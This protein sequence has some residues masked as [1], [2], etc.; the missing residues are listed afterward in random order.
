MKSLMAAIAAILLLAALAI[1]AEARSHK[2]HHHHLAALSQS[3]API[4]DSSDPRPGRWCMWWLR[5]ELGISKSQFRPYEY[6]LARAGRYLGSPASGP[7]VGVIV[8]WAHHVGIITGRSNSGW[9]IKSGND[10]H[11]VRERERPLHGVIAYRWPAGRMASS[12]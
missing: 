3:N 10:D 9:I 5:R 7:A 2:R 6:N 8:V 11:A 4:Y 1:P 12:S